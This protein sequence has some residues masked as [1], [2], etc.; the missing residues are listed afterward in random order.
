MLQQ[1]QVDRVIP[2]FERFIARFPDFHTLAQART[3]TLLFHWQG[4]G[5]NRRALM[6]QRCA[7]RVIAEQGGVLPDDHAA[8]VRLP[9]IGPY[10]AGAVLVFAF[11]RPYP[12]I[13]TNIRRAYLHHFFPHHTDVE[14]RLL[15]PLIERT[16]NR[17]SPRRWFSAL[18]D[19]GSW[20]SGQVPN[21]N[22][23]SRQ[24][25][26]QK[27]FQGSVR[28]LR[29][30][31]VRYMLTRKESTITGLCHHLDD[32]RANRV[33]EGL[34]KEGFLRVQGGKVRCA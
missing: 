5:Y 26:R 9:G 1:T 31:A 23:R 4:L 30:R 24:Y 14:D 6:L 15:L 34:T 2:F 32:D 7:R 29:G 3:R 13:E 18:M 33:I 25:V 21:P 27:P 16:M 22:V 11:D 20:L 17:R 28:Q 8:L 19:Y 12:L 10:T